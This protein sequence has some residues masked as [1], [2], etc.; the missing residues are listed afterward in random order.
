MG[1]NKVKIGILTFHRVKNLGANLQAFALNAYV[2]REI[3]DCEIIDFYPNNV[4]KPHANPVR[5]AMS[6][7][8]SLVRSCI[9]KKEHKFSSF[10]RKNYKLSPKKYYGDKDI[11]S[12]P[13]KYDI[14]ISGSDQILNTTLTGTSKSFYL[15]FDNTAKKISYASSFGRTDIS[16]DEY[17]LIEA[18]LPKFSAIS[19][20]EKSAG[21]IISKRIGI[22]CKTVLDPV[23]LLSKEEWSEKTVKANLPEKYIFVYAMEITEALQSAV[24]KAREQTGLPVYTVYG[25]VKQMGIDGTVIENS[26][27]CDFITYIKNASLVI[28]NSFHGTA[29]SIIFEKDFVCVAHSTRNARLE[30]IMSLI[31][32]GGKLISG[33]ADI[34]G[35]TVDG[36][37]A[38]RKI[39]PYID[40]SR[41][42]L[43]DNL[44][45]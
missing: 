34:N 6:S 45:T 24:G 36:S 22:D 8:K 42:Y 40:E 31:G 39:L 35:K 30:N 21:D 29:F 5:R 7:V 11:M 17:K 37:A 41:Q 28:T 32:E 12:F 33:E 38:A 2:N 19:V 4:G 14:L 15:A 27:P 10:Q 3:G 9:N 16:E 43:A 25:C 1:V 13:P 20:R 44:R 18:E 26:G 23:F